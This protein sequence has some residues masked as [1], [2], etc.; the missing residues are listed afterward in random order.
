VLSVRPSERR[1]VK[2]LLATYR[3]WLLARVW[4]ETIEPGKPRIRKQVAPTKEQKRL[5]NYLEQVI[6]RL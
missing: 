6:A 2:Y 5:A 3:Q 4:I 1:V